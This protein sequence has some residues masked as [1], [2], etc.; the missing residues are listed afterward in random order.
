MKAGFSVRDSIGVKMTTLLL[1]VFLPL[2]LYHFFL[3]R[4]EVDRYRAIDAEAC[5][6]HAGTVKNVLE[7]YL[8]TLL[9]SEL[10]LGQV[11]IEAGVDIHGAERHMQT[12]VRGNPLIS[13]LSILDPEGYVVAST[14]SGS[15][16]I[17]LG[18]RDHIQNVI[19]GADS[20]SSDLIKS[21]T[22]GRIGLMFSKAVRTE[23]QLLG[24]M[25]L[26]L[27]PD[28][29]GTLIEPLI[30]PRY[31][32]TLVDSK[33]HVI[34]GVSGNQRVT[35]FNKPKGV[36]KSVG[37]RGT[38][39]HAWIYA[40]DTGSPNPF[41]GYFWPILAT[42]SVTAASGTGTFIIWRSMQKRIGLLAKAAS[43]A[44]IKDF[45]MTTELSD[46]DQ[47]DKAARIIENLTRFVNTMLD[48][49]DAAVIVLEY[50]SMKFVISNK[51]HEELYK[52]ITGLECLDVH[53][54][55]KHINEVYSGKADEFI[56][57]ISRACDTG[58]TI[59]IIPHQP[60][61]FGKRPLYVKGVVTP[62][63]DDSGKV[64][65]VIAFVVNVTELV[66]TQR[67]L[68]NV[69]RQKDQLLSMASHELKTPLTILMSNAELIS[70]MYDDLGPEK[71]QRFL[72][73][74]TTQCKKLNR[75][76]NDLLDFS[77]LSNGHL[78]VVMQETELSDLI[79]EVVEEQ[80]AICRT[81]NVV[82]E[83]VV[84][85]TVKVDYQR[86]EQVV[87]N[88][89]TNG[90]RYSPS[91]SRVSVSMK[92]DESWVYVSVTDRGVGISAEELPRLFDPYYRSSSAKGTVPSGLG[93]GLYVAREIISLHGGDISA[94]SIL[95]SGSTFTIRLPAVN[96]P[97]R[98]K[99]A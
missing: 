29:M 15:E 70:L 41:R 34:Y 14:Y 99:T 35:V 1:L 44:S 19:E 90:V 10:F 50:P 61:D 85:R 3:L 78:N 74:F 40:P 62:I 66:R 7:S 95:G 64:T 20:S 52:E 76:V 11:I 30:P 2:F 96:T 32:F 13:R 51:Q 60:T 37:I 27:D 67:D 17:Y 75:L 68:E 36:Y 89:I 81:H 71:R 69:I 79:R 46:R 25:T 26:E 57:I 98:V 92:G 54:R 80:Q 42:V 91:G 45:H 43:K 63:K 5:S 28:K 23:E 47:L 72:S 94:E 87:S 22:T 58:K 33:E 24:I 49:I 53:F 82:L 55:G 31:N 9:D 77:R 21:R 84:Q 12:L 65:H 8:D 48:N 88:L 73:N 4:T 86:I 18:D 6:Q 56:N 16:G 83:S 39:W 97:T 59:P 38:K 93:L